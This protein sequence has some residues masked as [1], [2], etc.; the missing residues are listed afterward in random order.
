MKPYN[1]RDA[2]GWRIPREDTLSRKIY[3]LLVNGKRPVYIAKKLKVDVAK[4]NVLV[5]RFRN[6]EWAGLRR[7]QAEEASD[8]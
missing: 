5:H 7:R 2:R 8:A 4:V 3:D 1:A 6:P